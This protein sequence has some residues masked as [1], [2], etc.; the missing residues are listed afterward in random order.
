MPGNQVVSTLHQPKNDILVFFKFLQKKV[1]LLDKKAPAHFCIIWGVVIWKN[2]VAKPLD[3]FSKS[4]KIISYAKKPVHT[5][6]NFFLQKFEKCQD[7]ILGQRNVETACVR[8]SRASPGRKWPGLRVVCSKNFSR[9]TFFVFWSTQMVDIY[10]SY[11]LVKQIWWKN[12]VWASF[13]Y[14]SC[15]IFIFLIYAYS[16]LF[17][18]LEL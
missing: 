4:R 9:A 8:A 17:A 10:L 16:E 11:L 14:T 2:Q 12:A 18:Y 7:V 5:A 1:S 6:K 15:L 3:L 13:T